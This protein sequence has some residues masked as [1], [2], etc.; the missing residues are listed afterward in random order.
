MVV[1]QIWIQFI[2][3]FKELLHCHYNAELFNTC[4]FNQFC[5]LVHPALRRKDILYDLDRQKFNGFWQGYQFHFYESRKHLYQ[6]INR[7]S[8]RSYKPQNSEFCEFDNSDNAICNFTN[9]REYRAEKSNLACKRFCILG[10]WKKLWISFFQKKF[11][12]EV[13]NS[14]N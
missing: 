14:L 2:I 12:N 8:K 7:F 13:V 6:E 10:T 4:P 1:K 11:L 3:K 9:V 5:N